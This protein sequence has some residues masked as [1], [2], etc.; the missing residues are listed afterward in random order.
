MQTGFPAGR[1]YGY[2]NSP[3]KAKK[4]ECKCIPNIKSTLPALE[5]SV[6]SHHIMAKFPIS[7]KSA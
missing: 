1:Q 4:E 5:R 7:K 6:G 2:S 3:D